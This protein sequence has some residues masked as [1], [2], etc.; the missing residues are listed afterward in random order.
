MLLFY[1]PNTSQCLAAEGIIPEFR[2]NGKQAAAEEPGT[3]T[4][5]KKKF[6]RWG[7]EPAFEAYNG[8]GAHD[9]RKQGKEAQS[10]S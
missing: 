4:P 2:R 8:M 9:T 10:S 1:S 5:A 6:T 3:G 7:T